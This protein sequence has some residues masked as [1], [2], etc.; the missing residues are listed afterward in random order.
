[1]GRLSGDYDAYWMLSSASVPL[2]V[3]CYPTIET[4]L[5]HQVNHIDSSREMTEKLTL[6]YRPDRVQIFSGE[7]GNQSLTDFS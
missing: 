2:T 4:D 7:G 1:M 3:G 5:A 6:N